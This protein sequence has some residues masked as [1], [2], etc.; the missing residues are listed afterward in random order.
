VVNGGDLLRRDDAVA[1]ELRKRLANDSSV[2]K[3]QEYTYSLA[4][5]HKCKQGTPDALDLCQQ[6]WV[7]VAVV[8]G[9]GAAGARHGAVAGVLVAVGV[10][11]LE[12]SDELSSQVLGTI[13]AH[14]PLVLVVLACQAPRIRGACLVDLLESWPKRKLHKHT[15]VTAVS[16]LGALALG[17]PDSDVARVLCARR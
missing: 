10:E 11:G 2:R 8:G 5:L 13:A 12:L 4:D 1:Q 15:W 16:T 14:D 17:V 7:G 6:D 9:A 3:A